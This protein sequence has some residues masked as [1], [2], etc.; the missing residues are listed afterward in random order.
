MVD[1][2]I[3]Y[4]HQ[5]SE[6]NI[7]AAL[8]ELIG[9]GQLQ[10]DEVLVC[11]KA[12]YLTFD[13]NMPADPRA[14]FMKEYVEP[15]ILDPEEIVG[16]MHCMAPRFLADQL[17]RSRRNLGLET[18]DVYYV[19]NPE[20]QLAEIPPSQFVERLTAAFAELENAVKAGQD[21]LLRRGQLE[22]LSGGARSARLHAAGSGAALRL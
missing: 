16:G 22:R 17:E 20:T 1:T 10:R 4:R 5:R 13:G 3:N 8:A 6:R 18:I 21:S 12:G 9:A 11:S 2:A 15:G 14:Y 19:H 7:G